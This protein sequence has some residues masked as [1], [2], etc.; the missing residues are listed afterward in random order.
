V[1]GYQFL[2]NNKNYYAHAVYSK[3][4]FYART[5]SWRPPITQD[6]FWNTYVIPPEFLYYASWNSHKMWLCFVRFSQQTAVL[7][8]NCINRLG[9]VME[10][11]CFWD[12][13]PAKQ[14]LT[15]YTI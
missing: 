3:V 11:Q 6:M 8:P 13:F 2:Y 1:I 14:E 15:S 9:F 4:A 7:S 5:L 12:V 10:T